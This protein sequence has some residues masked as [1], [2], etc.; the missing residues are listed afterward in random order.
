M[1]KMA[2]IPPGGHGLR[3]KICQEING[4]YWEA[5]IW[6]SNSIIQVF[7][8]LSKHCDSPLIDNLVYFLL[9]LNDIMALTEVNK[10]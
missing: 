8:S 7:P 1:C 5:F 3:R 4:S 10:E 2:L 9:I 6:H